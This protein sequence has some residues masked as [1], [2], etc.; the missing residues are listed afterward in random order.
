[1]GVPSRVG[2]AIHVGGL[3]RT[4]G[5][6]SGLY[7]LYYRVVSPLLS[8][9]EV[10]MS[11]SLAANFVHCPL[12]VESM[13]TGRLGGLHVFCRLY[14]GWR[15]G[16]W[17]RGKVSVKYI[18]FHYI[19]NV[20]RKKVHYAKNPNILHAN[21]IDKHYRLLHHYN[22]QTILY[23]YGGIGIRVLSILPRTVASYC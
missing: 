1:M 16:W 8:R 4:Y 17:S 22:T 11:S 2:W 14:L 13:S 23:G 6:Y 20:G 18:K 12:L 9:K 3:R 21:S 15:C 5:G 7:R 19:F 10:H